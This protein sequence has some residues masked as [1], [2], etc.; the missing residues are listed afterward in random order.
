[1]IFFNKNKGSAII[2][3]G[4]VEFEDP[5]DHFLVRGF[6]FFRL[7]FEEGHAGFAQVEGDFD[8]IRFEDQLL[9]RRKEIPDHL[10]VQR[11]IGVANFL[12]HG[13]SF[14]IINHTTIGR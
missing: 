3:L 10:Q 2:I 4:G 8:G 9:R 6:V 7:L 13:F 5:A 12:F 1:M 14:H 11:L